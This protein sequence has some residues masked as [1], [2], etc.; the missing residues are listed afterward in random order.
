VKIRIAA[1]GNVS[2]VF[3]EG[4]I[5]QEDVLVLRKELLDL[6][7][8]GKVNIVLDMISSN[9]ISSMCLATIADVKKK[10]NDL[11]G[12]LKLAEPNEL[13]RNLLEETNFIQIIETFDN[14][15][16]AVKSFKSPNK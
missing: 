9:Y 1:V 15:D 8:D 2:V 13:I 16:A 3:I 6:V 5:L 4:N 12:N 7:E 11:G 14:V 10:V